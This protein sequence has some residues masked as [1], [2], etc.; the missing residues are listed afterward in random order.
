MPKQI[1]WPSPYCTKKKKKSH[2]RHLEFLSQ[3]SS[4]CSLAFRSLVHFKHEW[5]NHW[6]SPHSPS[7]MII[8]DIEGPLNH[9]WYFSHF[10]FGLIFSTPLIL[11]GSKALLDM[12]PTAPPASLQMRPYFVLRAFK[13][14]RE[15]FC[16]VFIECQLKHI[17]SRVYHMGWDYSLNDYPDF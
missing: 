8:S 7:F 12:G 14:E 2:F 10:C 17:V 15:H 5:S 4:N 6:R 13:K 3:T 16:S 9:L 11:R 1:C